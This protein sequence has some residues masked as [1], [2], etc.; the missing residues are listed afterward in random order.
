LSST[1]KFKKDVRVEEL[2]KERSVN[3]D[4]DLI[5]EMLRQLKKKNLKFNTFD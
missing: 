5:D 4:K 1:I 2:V 3:N